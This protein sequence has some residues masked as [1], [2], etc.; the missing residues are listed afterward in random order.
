MTVK[1]DIIRR[2][3]AVCTAL[4]KDITL[5]GVKNAG[6]IAGSYTILQETIALIND[7]EVIG[8]CEQEEN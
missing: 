8:K 4:D 7:C 6:V 5:T 3:D 2:I 1:E